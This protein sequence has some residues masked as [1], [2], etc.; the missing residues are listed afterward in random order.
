MFNLGISH[1][2]VVVIVGLIVFGPARLP[3]MMRTFGKVWRMVQLESEK[4]MAELK[5][6][7]DDSEIKEQL[8]LKVAMDT[9]DEMAIR[10]EAEAQA[11]AAAPIEPAPVVVKKSAPHTPK[12]RKTPPAKK[13]AAA[14]K[15]TAVPKKTTRS[16]PGAAKNA[17]AKNAA[18]KNG[19]A[20][21]TA[22]PESPP[23]KTAPAKTAK[24]A[25]KEASSITRPSRR[26]APGPS[27]ATIQAAIYPFTEDT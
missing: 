8:G 12:P 25:A 5:A 23:A 18:A 20:K 3:E 1:L 6:V 2:I 27:K 13:K 16:R 24:P 7:V 15:K 10:K 22:P 9:P 11:A 26:S 17:A 14:T 21:K 4:A 19:A